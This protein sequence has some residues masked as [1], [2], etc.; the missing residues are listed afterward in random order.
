MSQGGKQSLNLDVNGE[1]IPMHA[2]ALHTLR[3]QHAWVLSLRPM[4]HCLETMMQ[5]CVVNVHLGMMI[6]HVDNTFCGYEN[7]KT[8]SHPPSDYFQNCRRRDS[9]HPPRTF[10]F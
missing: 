9:E 5:E 4:N 6:N 10:F 8:T 1:N 3:L 7:I 2:A